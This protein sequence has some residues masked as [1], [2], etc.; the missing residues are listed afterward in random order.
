MADRNVRP[1]RAI[2]IE[3]PEQITLIILNRDCFVRLVQRSWHNRSFKETAEDL[4]EE[5]LIDETLEFCTA[6]SLINGMEDTVLSP[7][8]TPQP[9]QSYTMNFY[10]RRDPS[11]S[12]DEGPTDD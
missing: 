11:S 5:G 10:E 2:F 9:G 4:V 3:A 1:R 7:I 12:E 6:M 8:S